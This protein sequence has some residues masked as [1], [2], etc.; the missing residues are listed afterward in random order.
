MCTNANV[1]TCTDGGQPPD[2]YI[3]ATDWHPPCSVTLRGEP[4]MYIGPDSVAL[5]VHATRKTARNVLDVCC[6][7]G[8]QVQRMS[9]PACVHSNTPHSCMHACA[10]ICDHV[11]DP[12]MQ[13]PFCLDEQH[14]PEK[15]M[16]GA[17][18]PRKSASC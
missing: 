3:L 16:T 6:G 13:R 10:S 8:I 11:T 17:A 1:H 7:S 14:S 18:R 15:E 12:K 9:T 2:D 4:V 5:A